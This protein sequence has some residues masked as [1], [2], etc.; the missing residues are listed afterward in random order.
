V[1]LW[2]NEDPFIIGI[3]SLAI[4]DGCLRF[5]NSGSNC[6]FHA[7]ATFKLSGIGYPV[8]TC[9]FTDK[10]RAYQVGAFFVVS[11]EYTECFRS[12]VELIR[13]VRGV[14]LQVDTRGRRPIHRSRV[15][16]GVCGC[17]FHVLYYVRKRIQHLPT[18]IRMMVMSLIVDMH[19]ATGLLDF[20][21]CIDHEL[22]KWKGTTHLKEFA[23][24]FDSQW[25]KGWYW[26]WQTYHTPAGYVSTNNPCEN[27]NGAIKL[28]LQR[29]R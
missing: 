6:Q 3:T 12:F 14:S 7:D 24:Y 19:Y 13:E 11:H 2:S 17:F 1:G 4:I 8:V 21:L 16:F 18:K 10:A 5:A 23:T 9:G 28:F 25:R 22:Q 15:C 26:R 27:L 20:E 29:R